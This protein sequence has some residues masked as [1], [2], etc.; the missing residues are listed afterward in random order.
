M[1]FS[2][3][4]LTVVIFQNV[5]YNT[6]KADIQQSPHTQKKKISQWN[7]NQPG[8]HKLPRDLREIR[9]PFCSYV[10]IAKN[11]VTIFGFWRITFRNHRENI[12]VSMCV[13]ASVFGSIISVCFLGTWMSRR[14]IEQF[15]FFFLLHWIWCTIPINRNERSYRVPSVATICRKFWLFSCV[16]VELVLETTAV[17][18]STLF[19][20]C[21]IIFINILI[22]ISVVCCNRQRCIAYYGTKWWKL[23]SHGCTLF[24]G[25]FPHIVRSIFSL[26][27][28]FHRWI[29]TSKQTISLFL[30]AVLYCAIDARHIQ[31]VS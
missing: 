27:Q 15:Y 19:R 13:C 12:N 14:S 5:F 2:R 11:V 31:Y 28:L 16:L 10:Y 30:C 24:D 21:S 9:R 22:F 26:L 20:F 4:W 3:C 23:V 1:S 25:V 8:K 7:K 6:E 18:T 29:Y 17:E